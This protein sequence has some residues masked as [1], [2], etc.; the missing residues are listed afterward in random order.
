MGAVLAAVTSAEASAGAGHPSVLLSEASCE[1]KGGDGADTARAL[2]AEGE[3]LLVAPLDASQRSQASLRS[4]GRDGETARS[5]AEGLHV[6]V[7]E[8]A[9]VARTMLV[10]LLK[11]LQCTADEAEDG[12]QAVDKVKAA[13]RPYDMILC[14]SVMPNMDGPT[15]V[16]A[17]RE[18]GYGGPVLGVT[19][20]TLPEQIEDF[21][22]HGADAVVGKPVKLPVLKDAMARWAGK[23]KQAQAQAASPRHSRPV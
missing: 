23:G 22:Q 20:N 15:A 12:A 13:S 18:L 21:V 3:R 9:P 4:S 6:L 16:A 7:V 5:S 1:R 8:D 14:D 19:G 17:I 11:T 2:P 10:R